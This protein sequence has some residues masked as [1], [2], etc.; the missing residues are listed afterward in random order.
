MNKQEFIARLRKSLSG[1]PKEDIEEHLTFYAEM[2]DDRIEEGLSEEE[3]VS[4]AGD[5]GEIAAQAIADTPLSKIAVERIRP[6]RR[7]KAW[8]ILLLILG[9]PI[10]LSLLISMAVVI[11]SVYVSLW[12]VVISLWSVFATLAASSVGCVIAGA[13]LAGVKG[14]TQGTAFIAAGL[15]CAGVSVFAF[16]GCM[17]VTKGFLKLTKSVAV[18]AKNRFVN[19][20]DG[21]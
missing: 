3:A 9:S 17:A 20:E 12:A 14:I 15:V 5:I 2:I 11:I 19:K 8:E 13:V 7:L 1:L 21:I 4:E 10:W 16:L 18:W 6:K